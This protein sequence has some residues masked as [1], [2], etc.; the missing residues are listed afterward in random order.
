MSEFVQSLDMKRAD[1]PKKIAVAGFGE[2]KCDYQGMGKNRGNVIRNFREVVC[3]EAC[4]TPYG[5]FG[6]KLK[7]YDAPQL[8]ALAIKECMRRV[9]GKVKPED[10]DYVIMGQVIPA[11]CGQVPSRQ[12]TI[13]AG[14]PE[15]V[16]SITVNK[17]CSSGIKTIDL[18][19][20]MI[21]LGRA[22]I[23]IA[24]GQE[25]MSN[26]P[27][28]LPDERW[29][30][31]MGLP[32]GNLVDLMVYDG[33]WDTF[34]D[35]HMAIHGSETS[36][37][38]G[39]TREDN[40][41]WG[42]TSQMRAV[43]AMADNKFVDEIFPVAIKRGKEVLSADEGPRPQTTMEALAKLPPVFNHKSTV[44]GQPGSVTAGNAPGVN[45]GGDVCLLMSAEKA[46]EL[47]LKPLFTIL[48]YAE[49]SQQTKDIAT[50]PGLSI[51]K[52]LEQNGMTYKDVDLIEINEAFAA[53]VLTSARAVLGM[54][55]EEMLE[56]VN[57]N[58]SAIA[59]GHPIGAT[60]ARIVMTLAY[61]LK[62]RGGGIGICGICSGHAQGDAMLIKVEP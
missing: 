37:E 12:A 24:G 13:L 26:C 6:G 30:N 3:V 7:E 29:G 50:V 47:G 38:F 42:Y 55:K 5:V 58:G 27:F 15:S 49:V 46:K 31:R 39:F 32:K 59:Y 2:R 34:Y 8:G 10:I 14:L 62:R 23:V 33:L 9:T 61:E 19:V 16:P 36:D 40:D 28:S 20:Q 4:R 1:Y 54:S 48:D 45:D 57:V 11:G 52:V 44:T 17:V 21:Q 53:V 41:E 43:K 22:D 60:G 35:R 56:K 18:A 51:K 25:S